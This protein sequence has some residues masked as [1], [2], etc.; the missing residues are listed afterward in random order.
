MIGPLFAKTIRDARLFFFS[1]IVL[2]FFFP[3]FFVAASSLVSMPAFAEFVTRAFPDEL[4]RVWGVPFSE[5]ATPAGR[6]ALVFVH[7]LIL[8]CALGWSIARGSDC[9][10]GEIGRGTMEMLLAQPVRRISLFTSHALVT[11]GCSALLALAVWCGTIAGMRS[12]AVYEQVSAMRYI[13]PSL[14][15]FGLMVCMGGMSAL[16][17]SWD[18]QRWRT[19]G[20]VSGWYVISAALAIL[21]QIS[22][23]W[24]WV[25]YVSFLSPFKPQKMVA[26]S[27]AAWSLLSHAADHTAIGLGGMQLV[28]IAIGLVC[29]AVGA[30]I[31]ARR[32]IPAP[33]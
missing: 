31:F 24:S 18:S 3:W 16:A 23:R 19:I 10:S 7:P 20:L 33:I 30:V 17:S 27:N 22:D 8:L 5:V 26:Q 6:I 28:L 9:V 2:L 29:Y 1:V 11:I 32:E 14:N 12:T 25:G 21:G 15:L 4:Q 13:A